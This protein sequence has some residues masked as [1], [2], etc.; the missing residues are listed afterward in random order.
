MRWYPCYHLF[1]TLCYA[2]PNYL[3][4]TQMGVEEDVPTCGDLVG[5]ITHPLHDMVI[6]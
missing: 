1:Y 2:L 3:L 5:C 4:H 6:A